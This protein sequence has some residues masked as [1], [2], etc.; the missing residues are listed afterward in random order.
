[1]KSLLA[2][3]L[4]KI[5]NEK[6]YINDNL[7]NILPNELYE[8]TSKYSYC[9]IDDS[10]YDRICNSCPSCELT[11]YWN[12]HCYYCLSEIKENR[13]NELFCSNACNFMDISY[14][15]SD[16]AMN[17]CPNLYNKV[18]LYTKSIP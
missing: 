17:A 14:G 16:E 7:S 4:I 1:M 5:I 15:I 11:K 13:I 10:F 3:S 18:K 2:L 12:N 8:L 9:S 6:L